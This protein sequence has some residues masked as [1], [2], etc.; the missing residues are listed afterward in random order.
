MVQL[1][2]GFLS[3]VSL[4]F[5]NMQMIYI[6]HIGPLDERAGQIVSLMKYYMRHSWFDYGLELKYVCLFMCCC[7]FNLPHFKVSL[8][9]IHMQIRY[10]YI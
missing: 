3:Q 8:I 6:F 9:L 5:M 2:N 1:C 10:L 7:F 4:I